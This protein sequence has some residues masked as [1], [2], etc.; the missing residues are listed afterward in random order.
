MKPEIEDLINE[1]IRT[2]QFEWGA[3][4]PMSWWFTSLGLKHAA[5]RLYDLYYEAHERDHRRSLEEVRSGKMREGSRRLE[6]KE[7]ED[8]WD[9]MLIRPYRLLVGYAVENLLKG[10]LM[11]Q[12]P[13][14][15][16]PSGHVTGIKGHDLVSICSCCGIALTQEESDLLRKL[17]RSIVW[18]GKYPVP[19]DRN[20]MPPRKQR[21]GTWESEWEAYHG[22]Q[23]Q[24]EV[25]RLYARLLARL[26]TLSKAQDSHEGL[27]DN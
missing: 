8:S 5:D 15:L 10:I 19:L 23:Q 17:T 6:G 22:R 1:N 13:E 18:Q 25:D 2:K 14:N 7:L 3:K 24:Q 9:G 26:E 12:H 11:V 27:Q 16:K 20:H 4:L 21:D